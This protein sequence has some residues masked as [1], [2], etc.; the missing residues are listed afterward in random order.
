MVKAE[1]AITALGKEV[2]G[3]VIDDEEMIKK[4]Y[5]TK[6]FLNLIPGAAQFNSEI[7]PY[8]YPEG[9]KEL[10]IRVSTQSR[11]K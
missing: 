3:Y 10:G 2:T 6:Y 4:A 9:A 11:A 8:I 5:P 1:Q 7:L